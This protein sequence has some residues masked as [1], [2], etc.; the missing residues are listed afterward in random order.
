MISVIFLK[1]IVIFDFFSLLLLCTLNHRSY[2]Q[3]NSVN[4]LLKTTYIGKNTLFIAIVLCLVCKVALAQ[5]DYGV[6]ANIIYRFTKYIN[7]PESKKTGDFIIGIV[8]ETPLYDE[9]KYLTKN[10]RVGNQPIVVKR[11]SPTSKSFTAHILFVAAEE[12][13]RLRHITEMTADKPILIVSEHYGLIAKGS[14]INFIVVSDHLK[15]EFSKTNIEKRD[16]NIASELLNLGTVV[17]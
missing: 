2:N 12:S 15:L 6:Y 7:W 5:V 13:G 9:L 16:L 10:K 14:C 17:N 8:G 11:V 4:L 3:I 1:M